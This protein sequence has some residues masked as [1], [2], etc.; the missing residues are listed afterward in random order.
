MI[1]FQNIQT[2]HAAQYQR[3]KQPNQKM[4]RRTKQIF[5]QRRH[6]DGQEAHENM[7]NITNYQRNANKTTMRYH[8]TPVR[9]AVVKKIYK[10]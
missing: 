9:M 4:G 1:N 8:L 6:T 5:L 7:L 3:N 2:A 10:Q